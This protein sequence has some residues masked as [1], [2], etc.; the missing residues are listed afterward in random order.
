LWIEG[1]ELYLKDNIADVENRENRVVVVTCE[2]EIL[3]ETSKAGVA[4]VC[5]IDETEEVE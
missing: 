1:L 5:S 2:L 4:D 3:L